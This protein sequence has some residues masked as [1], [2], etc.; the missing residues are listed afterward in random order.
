MGLVNGGLVER[1]D[2]VDDGNDEHDETGHDRNIHRAKD[3]LG[4]KAP[5]KTRMIGPQDTQDE[6][7]VDDEDEQD[8]CVCKNLR[9]E[10]DASVF[11]VARPDDAHDVCRDTCHGEA[12]EEARQDELVASTTVSLKD[13]HVE[14]GGADEEE[15]DDGGD[16]DVDADGWGEAEACVFGG[17]GRTL[18]RNFM[19]VWFDLKIIVMG[20]VM[21]LK[22]ERGGGVDVPCVAALRRFGRWM[23]SFQMSFFG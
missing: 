16:G 15:E 4:W 3:D 6:D 11:R 21:V 2:A 23:P 14:G 7:D 19:L 9:R 18:R 10:T 1:V 22:G 8:T 20:L 5:A 12:E 17:V 13:C